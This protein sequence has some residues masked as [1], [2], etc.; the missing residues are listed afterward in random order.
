MSSGNITTEETRREAVHEEDVLAAQHLLSNRVLRRAL[1]IAA[2]ERVRVCGGGMA[3]LPDDAL[4][5]W[6]CWVMQASD[7]IE[8]ERSGH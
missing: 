2:S 8:A 5:F 7:Q 6:I 3:G 1:A 4:P